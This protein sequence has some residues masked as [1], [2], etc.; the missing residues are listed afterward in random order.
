MINTSERY[1]LEIPDKVVSGKDINRLIWVNGA[2]KLPQDDS[3]VMIDLRIHG[4]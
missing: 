4:Q 1:A 2:P 3:P